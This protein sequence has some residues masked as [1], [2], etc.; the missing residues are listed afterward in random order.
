MANSI[1]ELSNNRNGRNNRN[2]PQVLFLLDKEKICRVAER[3]S[4]VYDLRYPEEHACFACVRGGVRSVILVEDSGIFY[5]LS[6]K[7]GFSIDLYKGKEPFPAVVV[8]LDEDGVL[9]FI[10]GNVVLARDFIKVKRNCEAFESMFS[11]WARQE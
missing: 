4:E 6:E 3:E 1:N 9:P 8:N 11:E 2:E 7:D 10:T 5:P